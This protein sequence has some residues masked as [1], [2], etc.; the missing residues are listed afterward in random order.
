MGGAAVYGKASSATVTLAP[1]ARSGPGGRILW[2]VHLLIELLGYGAILLVELLIRCLPPRGAE[3]L[4]DGAAA[5]WYRLDGRRRMR[6]AEG[7]KVAMRG[8]LRVE[9]PTALSRRAFGSLIRVPIEVIRFRRY[10]RSSRELVA[11]CSFVGDYRQLQDDLAKNTGGLFVS[12]HLGNWE[13]AGWAIRFLD[14]PCSVVARPIENRFIDRR[15]TGTREGT[16][17]VIRKKGAVRSMMTKLKSGGW[18]GVMAD[19]NA[20]EHGMFVPFFG[21]PASTF[22]APA[23][24]ALRAGVPMY[25]AA[26]LRGTDPMTFTVHLERLPQP[27]PELDEDQSV[28][29][30]VEAYIRSLE[31]FVR[32]APEQYNWIHRRWKSRPPDEEPGPHLPAYARRLHAHWRP[33]RGG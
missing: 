26:C 29:F 1:R 27:P 18:V 13:V 4:A 20:S 25:S 12:G 2:R 24:L 3:M 9:D 31:G 11:R 30:L 23:V 19:Q 16:G 6:A 14:V 28:R 10:F 8:G 15:I 17:G 7:I 21:L 22:P 32:I 5:L 33:P